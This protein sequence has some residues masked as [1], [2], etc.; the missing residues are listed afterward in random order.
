VTARDHAAYPEFHRIAAAHDIAVDPL[1]PLPQAF[2]CAACGHSGFS[3]RAAVAELLVVDDAIRR[4]LLDQ[5]DAKSIESI[6]VAN[7]LVVLTAAGIQA[8]LGGLTTPGELIRV[9]GQSVAA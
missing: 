9:V 3:G 2:G 6:A 4:A 7:G 8:V 1:Q 5:S